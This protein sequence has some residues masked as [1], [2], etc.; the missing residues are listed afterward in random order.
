MKSICSNLL[1]IILLSF[2]F[3]LNTQQ[4]QCQAPSLCFQHF[5]PI[6]NA[7]AGD[8]VTLPLLVRGFELVAST[9][10]GIHYD[11]TGLELLDVVTDASDLTTYGAIYHQLYAPGLLLAI[12]YS[13]SLMG[14]SI[15]DS[16]IFL[17][18]KFRVKANAT[19]FLP[20]TIGDLGQTH[21]PFETIQMLPPDWRAVFF[22]LA[23]KIGGISVGSTMSDI[24]TAQK[25]CVTATSC[26]GSNGG[27]SIDITGGQPPYVY[28]WEGPGGFTA[29]DTP[30]ISGLTA[31]EYW[32]TVTDQVNNS[33]VLQMRVNA[34]F[35]T[36][37]ST[38]QIIQPSSCGLPNGCAT[39][40]GSNG[41]APYTYTWSAGSS[42]ESTNCNL[43]SG[44]FFVTITDALGCGTVR[45]GNIGG[46]SVLALNLTYQHITSCSELGSAEVN[47]LGTNDFQ[48]LWSTG[49]TTRTISQLAA[50]TYS[51]KVKAGG[52]CSTQQTFEIL[53]Q[54]ATFNLNLSVSQIVTC[55]GK[56]SASVA[57]N[58]V[59]PFQYLWSTGA[60]TAA[61][62]DLAAGTYSVIATGA[63][64]CIASKSFTIFKQSNTNWNF[65]A[66]HRC[67]PSDPDFGQVLLYYYSSGEGST[68][69]SLITWS[70]GAVHQPNMSD[71][72]EHF[73]ALVGLPVGAYTVTVTDT[74]GCTN[75]RSGW[76]DCA[77]LQEP[78]SGMSTFYIKD[79]YLDTQFSIDSCAGVY[80]QNFDG[81]QSLSFSLG[82]FTGAEFVGVRNFNLP[83]LDLS[84]FQINPES[85]TLSIDWASQNPVTLPPQTSLFEVCLTPSI[86]WINHRSIAFLDKPMGVKVV[87]GNGQEQAFIGKTGDVLFNL[88]FPLQPSSVETGVLPPDCSTDGNSQF[89][90]KQSNPELSMRVQVSKFNPVTNSYN[91]VG[92]QGSAIRLGAGLYSL[93]LEQAAS[94]EE[95]FLIKI[96]S[97]NEASQCVWPGDADNNNAVNH[98]DLLFIGMAYGETGHT[99]LGATSDWVGQDAIDWDVSSPTRKV[100]FKNADTNGDG[101]IDA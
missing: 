79:D 48:Y 18:L 4:V 53:Q 86:S 59:A 57:P 34:S 1:H 58:G 19:G 78:P 22:P 73:D 65:N 54:A 12:W 90:A 61:V 45:G 47:P 74:E 95:W 52:I 98:Y 32:V 94:E 8:E 62:S 76:L 35:S 3:H 83:G 36:I 50:G 38:L 92:N 97:N 93:S 13:D 2:L 25:I 75:T 44:Q 30:S 77:Q 16:S 40:T 21:T 69:P 100:N 29:T 33:A 66:S 85:K 7:Q 55:T 43:P 71:E 26:N 23:Q 72:V 88:Y 99:R 28:Q 5:S 101:T 49:D 42:T 39:V 80:A 81:I 60:T 64:G 84:N 82:W 6:V 14:V 20:V 51:V 56:G 68:A 96:P 10:L 70:N 15:P 31:G 63:D 41:Q 46:T 11:S 9:Q 27:A 17:E 87:G 91:F 67:D 37:G 24:L 89:C